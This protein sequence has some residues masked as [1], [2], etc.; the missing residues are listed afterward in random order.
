ME[1]KEPN[2]KRPACIQLKMTP[3][4]SSKSGTSFASLKESVGKIP[5]ED[6]F[7]KDFLFLAFA[8][9][10]GGAKMIKTKAPPSGGIWTQLADTVFVM[11]A[12]LRIRIRDPVPFDPWT[13]S[14]I[15]FFSGSRIPGPSPIYFRAW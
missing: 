11:E 4:R 6:T 15:G 8:G 12:V 2:S 9:A 3:H 7:R 1:E 14:G 5:A 10:V 13:R